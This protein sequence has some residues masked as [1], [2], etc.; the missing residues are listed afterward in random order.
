MSPLDP[1]THKV[2]KNDDF[3][4]TEQNIN[5]Q[6]SCCCVFGSSFGTLAVSSVYD[7]CVCPIP[8]HKQQKIENE[9]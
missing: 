9:E 1:H 2:K 7:F 4:R 6:C 8:K 3:Y 5:N